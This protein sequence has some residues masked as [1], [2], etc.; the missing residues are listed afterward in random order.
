MAI[1]LKAKDDFY[2]VN[3]GWSFNLRS[4]RVT[5]QKVKAE[6][7]GRSHKPK[8]FDVAQKVTVHF[9]DYEDLLGNRE[10]HPV[11]IQD[12]A[13]AELWTNQSNGHD[14]VKLA[15]TLSGVPAPVPA[16]SA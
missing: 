7:V 6:L 9:Q 8:I 11:L 12:G 13:K 2:Q 1:F 15:R 3:I 4:G 5:L 14:I 10:R 16:P